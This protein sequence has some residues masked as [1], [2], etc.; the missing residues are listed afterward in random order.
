M[1]HALRDIKDQMVTCS[2]EES[3]SDDRY[4]RFDL[5][6]NSVTIYVETQNVQVGI[7]QVFRLRKR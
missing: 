5:S 1:R 2:D 3:Y 7:S 6:S 4:I